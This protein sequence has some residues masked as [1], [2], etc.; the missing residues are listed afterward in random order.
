VKEINN[1]NK[2]KESGVFWVEK[3]TQKYYAVLFGG[4]G[5]PLVT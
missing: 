1:D 5:L 4:H 2:Q 3:E